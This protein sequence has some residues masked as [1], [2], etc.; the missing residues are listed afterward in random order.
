MI[1]VTTTEV[2]AKVHSVHLVNVEHR[3][4]SDQSTSLGGYKSTCYRQLSSKTVVIPE[5]K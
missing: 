3:R 2:I 1:I 5:G 4:P